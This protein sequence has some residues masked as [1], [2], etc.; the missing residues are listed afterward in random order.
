[1]AITYNAGMTMP[2]T[3]ARRRATIDKA[4]SALASMLEDLFEGRDIPQST[5]REAAWARM[6]E[7]FRAY[8]R[9]E[10]AKAELL[11]PLA[12]RWA[13][14]CEIYDNGIDLGIIRAGDTA[15]DGRAVWISPTNG[16]WTL[17]LASQDQRQGSQ[18]IRQ[19][20]AGQQEVV[21]R[22]DE[23]LAEMTSDLVGTDITAQEVYRT[24]LR[25]FVGPAL[26]RQGYKGSSGHY[27]RAVGDYQVEIGCQ[28]SKWSTKD[29]VEY[30]LELSV[31]HPETAQTYDRANAEAWAQGREHEEAPAGA[32]FSSFPGNVGPR[33]RFWIGLRPADDLSSHANQLL[34]DLARYVF[35]EIERQL[36]LPLSTPTPPSERPVEPSREQRNREGLSTML[37]ALRAAGVDVDVPEDF[38]A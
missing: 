36:Q 28:K 17:R 11:S 16:G 21:Q 7:S 33:R 31:E 27:H 6:V 12:S 4:P 26:R 23:L 34:S 1:M 22:L 38:E 15:D 19:V 24:L 32:W 9:S 30:R 20:E 13:G 37:A 8:G 35:P 3:V 14:I 10:G 5:G 2:H 18:L 29:R 25:D